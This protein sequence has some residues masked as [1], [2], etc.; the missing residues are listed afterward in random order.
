[1]TG[2]EGRSLS[3]AKNSG[4]SIIIYTYI[5]N[6]FFCYF[7]YLFYFFIILFIY[8]YCIIAHV[9]V[10]LYKYPASNLALTFILVNNKL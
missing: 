2:R 3:E 7:F 1:M 8:Y 5:I 6:K 10:R 4:Y 9:R